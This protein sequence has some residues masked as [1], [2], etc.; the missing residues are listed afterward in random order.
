M[1]IHLDI[2]DGIDQVVAMECVRRVLADGRISNGGKSYCLGTSFLTEDGVVWVCTRQHRKSDCFL[3][4]KDGG[5]KKKPHK[6]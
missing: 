1:K 5:I 2:R 4:Y 3:V 6:A